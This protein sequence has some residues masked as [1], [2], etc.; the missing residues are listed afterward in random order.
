MLPR[1][2]SDS[3]RTSI[4]RWTARRATQ[5]LT[6]TL[7]LR[8]ESDDRR[9]GQ[10]AVSRHPLFNITCIMGGLDAEA[11]RVRGGFRRYLACRLLTALRNARVGTSPRRY[12][13]AP[14]A[15]ASP[16]GC[17][18][19]ASQLHRWLLSTE[20]RFASDARWII[21]CPS[22]QPFRTPGCAR[23]MVCA[24]PAFLGLRKRSLRYWQSRRTFK[25][26]P[27]LRVWSDSACHRAPICGVA[28]QLRQI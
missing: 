16:Y 21:F 27:A 11:L 25:A 7:R 18:R 6:V 8:F 2:A 14:C 17:F 10:Q 28:E 20:R 24:L 5:F 23:E 1:L 26:K 19:S 13:C 22:T 15:C 3:S 12:V 9:S 4:C